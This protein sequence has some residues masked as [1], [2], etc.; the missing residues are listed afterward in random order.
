MRSKQT[1]IL[2][3]LHA[4]FSLAS[5]ALFGSLAAFTI[6][7]NA[8]SHILSQKNWHTL[9][10]RSAPMP[11]IAMLAARAYLAPTAV[12]MGSARLALQR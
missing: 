12:A 4:S 10:L 8:N 7:S 2:R 1:Y 11:P 3:R 5:L 6:A 9:S